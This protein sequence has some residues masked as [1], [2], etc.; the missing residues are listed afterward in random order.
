MYRLGSMLAVAALACA[1]F[2]GQTSASPSVSKHSSQFADIIAQTVEIPQDTS[3]IVDDAKAIDIKGRLIQSSVTRPEI[4][5]GDVDVEGDVVNITGRAVV[6]APQHQH[7][8][9]TQIS[10]DELATGTDDLSRIP[11]ARTK[12]P[13]SGRIYYGFFYGYARY[14]RRCYRL[15]SRV[16]HARYRN[17][18][19]YNCY[20]KIRYGGN[21]ICVDPICYAVIYYWRV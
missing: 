9:I 5:Q 14:A 12:L 18:R 7:D 21:Y 3:R 15:R 20:R 13:T 1:L 17:I 6:D 2:F 19:G 16:I 10:V 4:P 11:S 8:S